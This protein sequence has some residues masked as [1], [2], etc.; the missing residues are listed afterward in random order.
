LFAVLN[1]CICIYMYLGVLVTFGHISGIEAKNG[2]IHSSQVILV[3]CV[4]IVPVM[5]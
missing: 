3:L 1:V 4:K 2:K 5:H